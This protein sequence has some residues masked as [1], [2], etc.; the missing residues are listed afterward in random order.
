MKL[1]GF[2]VDGMGQLGGGGQNSSRNQQQQVG[3]NNNSNGSPYNNNK[4]NATGVKSDIF[5]KSASCLPMPSPK[6]QTT[7]ITNLLDNT[8]DDGKGIDGSSS[9]SALKYLTEVRGLTRQ[10]LRKFGVGLG[11]YRFPSVEP[12]QHNR[13][14]KADC[15]TF[16]WIM[17]SSEIHEQETLRGGSFVAPSQPQQQGDEG[18][19]LR[20]PFVTRRVKARALDNKANQR[21]D[22]PG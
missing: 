11:S 7:Y 4:N 1:G 3:N 16:P 19:G 13:F 2:E 14:V 6:L 5:N 22:P 15:I 10:T 20:D 9:A 17:K 8:T 21:L 12:G 18:T